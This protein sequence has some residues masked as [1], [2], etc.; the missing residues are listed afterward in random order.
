MPFPS[1]QVLPLIDAIAIL[2][3]QAYQLARVR[4]ASA[5]S[6][7]LRLIMQRDQAALRLHLLRRELDIL[8]CQRACLLPHRRP[9]YQPQQRLAILQLRRLRGWSTAK[10]AARFVIHPNTLRSWIAAIEGHGNQRLLAG[11]VVWNRIDDTVRWTVREL[12][13]LCPQPELG[14]RTIARLIVRA[15]LAISRTTVQRVLREPQPSRPACRKREPMPPPAGVEPRHL[16]RPKHPNHVWHIDLTSLR[17]L[18]F[19]FTVAAML[20]GFSRKLLGLRVFVRTPRQ[21]DMIGFV[22][23]T[24]HEHGSP[25]FLISDHGTQFRKRF[26]AAMSRMSIRHVRGRVRTPYLNGKIERLFRT[27]RIWASM[28]LLPFGRLAVQRRVEAFRHW[29]NHHRPHAAL[30]GR[31]P[32]EAWQGTLLPKPIAIRQRDAVKPTISIRRVNCRGDPFLPIVQITV[33]RAA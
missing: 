24:A 29:Y 33:R 11:I 15:G 22:R 31:T 7:I 26:H 16:L 25:R 17:L 14:T 9:D 4:L 5:A 1:A 28:L 13:R 10:T 8:R 12:R 27:W 21:R 6:P 19:G 2:L 32:E 18:W 3:A 30:R 20:D 23:Q